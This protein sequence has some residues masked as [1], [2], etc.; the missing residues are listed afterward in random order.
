MTKKSAPNKRFSLTKSSSSSSTDD[1]SF[2]LFIKKTSPKSK[3]NNKENVRPDSQLG[4]YERNKHKFLEIDE[5][6]AT[7]S[8][9]S[10]K[11]KCVKLTQKP[12]ALGPIETNTSSNQKAVS[13]QESINETRNLI[14][15]DSDSDSDLPELNETIDAKDHLE[16]PSYS[17]IES[18]TKL[19]IDDSSSQAEI[20]DSSPPIPLIDNIH[21]IF[22]HEPYETYRF[23]IE[24]KNEFTLERIRQLIPPG[25]DHIEIILGTN[26]D[27]YASSYTELITD[28]LG[29]E[30]DTDEYALNES[31]GESLVHTE[32][33]N[34]DEL[35]TGKS[36]AELDDYA[37]AFSHSFSSPNE[38]IDSSNIDYL[39]RFSEVLQTVTSLIDNVERRVEF[40]NTIPAIKEVSAEKTPYKT[41]Y[42]PKKSPVNANNEIFGKNKETG[43]SIVITKMDRES[44]INFSKLKPKMENSNGEDTKRI[45]TN[46]A[47]LNETKQSI[48]NSKNIG[49]KICSLKS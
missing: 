25:E 8:P 34:F 30:D 4:Y 28:L 5:E 9:A 17:P 45:E 23:Q 24:P 1:T 13:F 11:V 38:C 32:E 21:L 40:D 42:I 18:P 2:N 31:L 22:D 10:K 14:L 37:D 48:A 6:D 29:L 43:S 19:I 39:T 46:K 41:E 33:E 3:S 49:K 44:K 36:E 12:G 15:H 27:S 47:S 16:S 35:Q 26:S 20:N 7:C